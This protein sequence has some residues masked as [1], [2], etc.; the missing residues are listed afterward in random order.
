[1]LILNPRGGIVSQPD[2]VDGDPLGI[3]GTG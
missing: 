2:G 1:V 3:A